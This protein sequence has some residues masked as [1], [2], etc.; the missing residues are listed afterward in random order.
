[1]AADRAVLARARPALARAH[2]GG[3][4]EQ[5]GGKHRGEVEL[6]MVS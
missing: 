5:G 6:G 4:G 2:A 3:E 1:M